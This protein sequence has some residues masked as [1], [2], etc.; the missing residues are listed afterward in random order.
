MECLSQAPDLCLKFPRIPFLARPVSVGAK[1][2]EASET[3]EFLAGFGY[4]NT[5]CSSHVR[6]KL[7]ISGPL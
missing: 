7:G 5:A 2:V 1:M 6:C 4:F 3:A